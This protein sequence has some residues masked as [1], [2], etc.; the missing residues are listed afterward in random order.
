VLSAGERQVDRPLALKSLRTL[1]LNQGDADEGIRNVLR[2]A[3]YHGDDDAT[4]QGAQAVLDDVES[5][6]N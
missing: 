4:V 3:I 6:P 2:Q 5:A 1:A